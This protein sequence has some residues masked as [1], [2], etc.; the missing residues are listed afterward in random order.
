[1]TE[2]FRLFDGLTSFMS[3]LCLVHFCS[4]GPG[5]TFDLSS[6][7]RSSSSVSG[8]F[9]EPGQ[10]RQGNACEP[11]GHQD[12]EDGREPP[13]QGTIAVLRRAERLKHAPDPVPEVKRQHDH[14]YDVNHAYDAL[15]T[16]DQVVVDGAFL[17]IRMHGAGCQVQNMVDDEREDQGPRDGHRPRGEARLLV[18][19]GLIGLWPCLQVLARQGDISPDMQ[20]DRREQDEAEGPE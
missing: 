15:E 14:R 11:Q 6:T 13:P 7:G 5:G 12:R 20:S 10:D 16:D 8:L 4:I 9:D 1:M 18:L 2:Y 19:P 17:K 3:N